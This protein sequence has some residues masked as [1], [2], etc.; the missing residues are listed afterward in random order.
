MLVTHSLTQMVYLHY[1]LVTNNFLHPS[2]P[3]IRRL[4][5]MSQL[6]VLCTA[7]GEIS[8]PQAEELFGKVFKV[9]ENHKSGWATATG[10][11]EEGLRRAGVALGMCCQHCFAG[12]GGGK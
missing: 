9:L 5:I 2:W 1:E 3:Q 11:L 6:L 12:D 4:A 10:R 8:T 7:Q